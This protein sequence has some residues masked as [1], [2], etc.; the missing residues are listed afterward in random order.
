VLDTVQ[1]CPAPGV[2]VTLEQGDGRGQWRVIGRG[3]TDP[4][5]RLQTL[6]DAGAP[7]APGP[8]RLTFETQAYFEA[9]GL[10]VF[11]PAVTV[12]FVAAAGE[13]HYH[14]PLLLGT[15]GYTTYRGS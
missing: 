15:F 5:G 2:A 7:L 12:A 1:G 13:T 3:E 14:V 8:Y 6:M 11:Y 10:P 4:S 9:N